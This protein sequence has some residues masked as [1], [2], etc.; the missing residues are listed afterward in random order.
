MSEPSRDR[1]AG[2]RDRRDDGRPTQQRPRDR[3]GRPLPYGTR[4]VLLS[5]EVAPTTTDEALRL[6]A[7]RWEQHRYFEAHESLEVVWKQAPVED[8][9]LWKGV[10]QV[11]VAGVHLQRGNPIGALRLLDRALGRLD[12]QPPAHRGI[13][14]AALRATAA[15]ARARL[16]AG[17]LPAADWGRFPAHPARPSG[18]PGAVS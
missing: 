14:V 6:G 1:A 17:E 3:T 8:R 16:D 9:D 5:E 2:D 4:D 12:G 7:D 10:I 11:A 13:D 15:A 18:P